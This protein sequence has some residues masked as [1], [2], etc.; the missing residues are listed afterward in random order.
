MWG[1][2]AICFFKLLYFWL[3]WG[4]PGGL[5]PSWDPHMNP[6]LGFFLGGIPDQSPTVG[7]QTTMSSNEKRAPGCLGYTG[8]YTTK[9]YRDYNK[10][11]KGSRH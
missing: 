9:L 6:G 3:V 4:G 8:D 11:L 10:P 1:G 2:L 7:P 5:G